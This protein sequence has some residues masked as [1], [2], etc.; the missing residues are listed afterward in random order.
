VTKAQYK[1]RVQDHLNALLAPLPQPCGESFLDVFDDK[2]KLATNLKLMRAFL[3]A[4]G[5][6]G[7]PTR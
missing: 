2:Y 3:N 4:G 6:I 5:G 7:H 1:V